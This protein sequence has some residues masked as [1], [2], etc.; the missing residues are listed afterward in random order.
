M[1][2]GEPVRLKR[3]H[4]K[5]KIAP[6][7]PKLKPNLP[8]LDELAAA[9]EAARHAL[10]GNGKLQRGCD[11]LRKCLQTIMV[12]EMDNQTRLPVTARELRAL[13]AEGLA[14]FGALAGQ[15]WRSPKN[16][17]VETRA[18]DINQA[19]LEGEGYG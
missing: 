13:A 3:S 17:V 7:T 14:E 1:N 8:P 12:A 9:Q 4:H 6:A 15:D 16:R 11:V 10:E 19:T 18:G 2:V 5:K